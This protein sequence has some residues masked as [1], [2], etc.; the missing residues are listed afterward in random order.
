MEKVQSGF[1]EQL[2]AE[3]RQRVIA[4]LVQILIHYLMQAQEV[5]DDREQN[6][7]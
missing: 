6:P 5:E 2:S 3:E 1:W 7:V 4:V